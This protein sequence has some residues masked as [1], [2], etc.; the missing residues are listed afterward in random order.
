MRW[1][2]EE[3]KRKENAGIRKSGVAEFWVE[4]VHLL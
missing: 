4:R 2:E 1:R 3:M